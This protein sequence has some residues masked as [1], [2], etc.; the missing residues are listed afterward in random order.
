MSSDIQLH[1]TSIQNIR[2]VSFAHH[3]V[4]LLDRRAS[5]GALLTDWGCRERWRYSRMSC[6]RTCPLLAGDV[7]RLCCPLVVVRMLSGG[8]A[9]PVLCGQVL[10]ARGHLRLRGEGAI[11]SFQRMSSVPSSCIVSQ[12]QSTIVWHGSD[13]SHP[14]QLELDEASFG[15]SVKGAPLRVVPGSHLNSVLRVFESFLWFAFS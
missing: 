9:Q 8:W 10:L 6:A 7:S 2:A 5:S 13:P 14:L 1:N 11:R 15:L 12:A 3:G 4:L